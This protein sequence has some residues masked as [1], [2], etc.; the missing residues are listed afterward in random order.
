MEKQKN[1]LLLRLLQGNAWSTSLARAGRE[2]FDTVSLTPGC[3]QR[4]WRMPT[5]FVQAPKECFDIGVYASR[6]KPGVEFA[7]N[8]YGCTKVI[9]ADLYPGGVLVV[10]T[11]FGSVLAKMAMAYI[12]VEPGRYVHQN[13]GSFRPW[14]EGDAFDLVELHHG[15]VPGRFDA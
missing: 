10:L 2:R 14:E 7:R 1:D 6:L 13:G 11:D 3:V 9:R 5:E 8:E 4:L 12:F 15:R